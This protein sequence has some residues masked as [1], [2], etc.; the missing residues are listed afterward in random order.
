MA[1]LEKISK[2][3]LVRIIGILRP[4]K[5]IAPKELPLNYF[6][7][8]LIV[9]QHDQLGDLLITTPT[10]RAVRKRFPDA[11]IGVVVR[12]YTAPMIWENPNVD[13]IIVFSEKLSMWNT[14]K[15][16][17]FLDQLRQFGGYDCAIMLNTISR[18]L[19]SDIIAVLSRAKYIVGP[20]H[21]QLIPGPERIY[22]SLT[23]RSETVQLEIQHN[24]DI[25]SELNVQPDGYEYDLHLDDAE[26]TEAEKVFYS[27]GVRNSQLVIGVHFGTLDVTRRLP[28]KTLAKVIDWIKS[29]YECEIVLIVG[30]NERKL[31]DQLLRMVRS[32]IRSAPVMPVRVAAAFIKRLQLFLCNDTGTL[33]IA[34]AMKVPTVSFHSLN[35]PAVWKP[36]HERHIAVRANDA[37]ITSI[38]LEQIIDALQRQLSNYPQL[39]P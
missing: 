9:R 35:D 26:I 37:K 18:S 1:F 21:L 38:T 39:K 19:S 16:R 28:L 10:I 33:H 36:P 31:Q 7:R 23:H 5:A 11:H 12:N 17:S 29:H 20:D 22:D 2:T 8:I 15:I 24:L 27:V 3:L 6:K 25:V 30:P 34:A 4:P 13:E 32:K 14:L